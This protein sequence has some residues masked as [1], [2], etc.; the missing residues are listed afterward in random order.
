M[1]STCLAAHSVH[2]CCADDR[3]HVLPGANH[4]PLTRKEFR[5]AGMDHQGSYAA[6]E[7]SHT[8]G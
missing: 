2:A 7:A 6:E 4:E 3:F 8:D 5:V 1:L